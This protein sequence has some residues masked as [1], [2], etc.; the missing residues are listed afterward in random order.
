MVR[1]TD[2]IRWIGDECQSEKG[3]RMIGN[4]MFIRRRLVLFFYSKRIRRNARG[5][6]RER[7]GGN[8]S[9]KDGLEHSIIDRY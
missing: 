9:E 8:P 6:I 7:R 2:G 1:W 4:D 3:G 5:A